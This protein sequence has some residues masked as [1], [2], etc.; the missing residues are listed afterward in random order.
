[1]SYSNVFIAR[2]VPISNAGILAAGLPV[3]ARFAIK[4]LSRQGTRIRQGLLL[5]GS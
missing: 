2:A 4:K 1:L 5:G 3:A